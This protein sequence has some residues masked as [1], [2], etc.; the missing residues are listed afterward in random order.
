MADQRVTDKAQITAISDADVFHIVDVS[1][2]SQNAAGSSF[3]GTIG[4]LR[5]LFAP[6]IEAPAETPDGNRTIFT[7]AHIPDYINA[8]G[9]TYY[10]GTG[11]NNFTPAA[12]VV[13][14]PIAPSDTDDV[15][16]HYH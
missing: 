11:A 14:L 12:L 10:P 16:S 8:G 15:R 4:Q 1:D 2:T 13:T 7:F 6:L 9:I 3:K 5:A